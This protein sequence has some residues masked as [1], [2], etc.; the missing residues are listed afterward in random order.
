M[1]KIDQTENGLHH[2]VDDVLEEN[3]WIIVEM[4][5]H[6]WEL[7]ENVEWYILNPEKKPF[8]VYR[9]HELADAIKQGQQWT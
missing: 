5:D 3:G 6:T 7:Y 4:K 9:N 1:I 8:K 2:I